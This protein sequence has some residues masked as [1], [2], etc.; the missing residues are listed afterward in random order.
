[1]TDA[2]FSLLVKQSGF[3]TLQKDRHFDAVGA[4][5]DPQRRNLVKGEV[6]RK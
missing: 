4:Q 1:M 3:S 6:C 2:L 5:P